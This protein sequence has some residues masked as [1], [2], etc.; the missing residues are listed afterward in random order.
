MWC[1]VHAVNCAWILSSH[2]ISISTTILLIRWRTSQ[3]QQLIASASQNVPTNHWFLTVISYF[4]NFRPGI[5]SLWYSHMGWWEWR[6]HGS[7]VS[8]ALVAP[9]APGRRRNR[10]WTIQWRRTRSDVSGDRPIHPCRGP[11]NWRKR[12]DWRLGPSQKKGLKERIDFLAPCKL[13]DMDVFPNLGLIFVEHM[14]FL[15]IAPSTYRQMT[16]E[17]ISVHLKWI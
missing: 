12:P 8:R 14:C 11:R 7:I 6:S 1:L 17:I 15:S 10:P 5:W 2:F 3:L 13:Q 4:P 9:V 16:F